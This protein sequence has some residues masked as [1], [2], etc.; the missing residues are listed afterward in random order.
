MPMLDM[1]M[2]GKRLLKTPL[3]IMKQFMGVLEE[4]LFKLNNDDQ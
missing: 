4:L 1:P 3:M 2:N